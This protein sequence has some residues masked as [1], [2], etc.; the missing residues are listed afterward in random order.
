MKKTTA[1]DRIRNIGLTAHID[2]GKTTITERIL[3]F[4]G[5]SHK[6]GEV[7]DG[8]AAMDWMVQERERGITI[9][10]AATTTYWKDCRI[11][12]IDTPGHV[13]FTAEVERALR[14]LDGTVALFCAVGGV[15]PQSETVWR[16]AEKYQVPRIAFINKMDRNGADFE[17]VVLEIKEAFG[18]NPVPVVIPIDSGPEFQGIVDLVKMRAIYYDNEAGALPREEPV[19][20]ELREAARRAQEIMVERI[21]EQDDRL[22]EKFVNG[23]P[24]PPDQLLRS[25]RRA[26]IKGEIIPVLCGAA[27][28][29]K[30]IRRLL[31]AIVDYL[32]SPLD[33]PPVI[34][35]MDESNHQII[36]KPNIQAPLAALAFKIQL[37]R[38]M[39]KLTYLRVYSGVLRE[40]TLVYNSNRDK[41]QRIGRLFEMH[42][43]KQLALKELQAGEV[44][45]IVGLA[46]T[47]T[48]DTICD[49]KHPIVLE[50]IEFPAP[51]L[52]VAIAPESAGDQEKLGKALRRLADE[53]PTFMVKNNAET[54]ELIISGMGELHLEIILDRLRREFN[55][56]VNSSPPQ[57]SYRE[58]ILR[59]VKQEHKHIKQTGGH[60]QYAHVIFRLEPGQ[61]GTGLQFENEVRGGRIPREYIP[62]IERGVIEAMTEGPYAGFPMVDILVRLLDGSAHEVDSSEQAFRTC[63]RMGFRAGCRKAGLQLLEPI[64]SMEVTAPDEYIGAI[65]ASICSQRG[66]ITQVQSRERNS[67]LR[68]LV[69]LASMFGYVTRLRSMTSGRGEFTMRFEHYAAVPFQIAEKIAEERRKS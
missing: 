59:A 9:T 34:G 12:I 6:M 30:G 28:K 27:F 50:N 23:E 31:D 16:Q 24:L 54:G 35:T 56:E 61:P 5:K 55:L 11:N 60:G 7:H 63:G 4:T 8:Q 19:P 58:T 18:A 65:T 45:A 36:R 44:G 29:N 41:T 68:G 43:D 3:F 13:D 49:Q 25:L 26:T 32:P 40:G 14:V 48:G 66:Q 39:G 51:V 67:I 20:P 46:D 47:V 37:H 21:C 52:E 42:A 22:L 10:S 64:M 17:K 38:H 69:P 33:R 2:A 53:D 1:I 62:A 57:V 15:Q